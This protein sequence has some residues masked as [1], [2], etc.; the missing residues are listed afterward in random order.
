MC[1]SVALMFQVGESATYHN[2]RCIATKSWSL[3]AVQF[4]KCS[5]HILSDMTVLLFLKQDGW[6]QGIT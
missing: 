6:M 1:P 5:S 4:P 2:V 3:I